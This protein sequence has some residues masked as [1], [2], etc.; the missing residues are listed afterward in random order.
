VTL[1]YEN[2]HYKYIFTLWF[3]KATASRNHA[4]LLTVNLRKQPEK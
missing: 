1:G 3:L 2:C 4:F